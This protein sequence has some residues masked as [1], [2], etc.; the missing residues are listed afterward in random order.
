MM[1]VILVRHAETEW[2]ARGIIQG[3]KDS[4]LT[5]AGQRETAA[6]LE[7]FAENDYEVERVYASPLGRTWKMGGILAEHF[8][9]SLVA[10]GCLKE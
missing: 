6:L 1:K 2:N 8:R 9:C 7:A 4:A 3:Q 10:E 5:E